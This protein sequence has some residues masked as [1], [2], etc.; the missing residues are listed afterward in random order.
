MNKKQ[1]A[2]LRGYSEWKAVPYNLSYSWGSDVMAIG[3]PNTIKIE[4]IDDISTATSQSIT[5]NGE[6]KNLLFR[7]RNNVY[8]S[9]D[10]GEIL[11]QL[12]LGK[13]IGGEIADSYEVFLE[14]HTGMELENVT[15]FTDPKQQDEHIKIRVSETGGDDFV[16][17]ESFT[18][19]GTMQHNDVKKFYVR[20]EADNIIT[21]VQNN[22]YNIY[23][24]GDPIIA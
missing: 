17:S 9:T 13:I 14:N 16:P 19:S 6:Y 1:I 15:V 12:D 4:V 3:M 10:K 7:D 18:Y 23:A 8:Y 2:P 21:A 20:A 24:K 5:V 22:V 11:E